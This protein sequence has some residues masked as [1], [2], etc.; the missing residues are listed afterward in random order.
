MPMPA[1]LTPKRDRT[2]CFIAANDDDRSRAHVLLLADNLLDSLIREI[3][4]RL[5]RVFKI[6]GL[7]RCLARRHRRRQINEPV[8]IH[9]E[10]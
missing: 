2:A 8:R 5:G 4:E 1:S 3:A 10:P 6:A 7:F 9:G